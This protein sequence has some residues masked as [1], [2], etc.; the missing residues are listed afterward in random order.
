MERSDQNSRGRI[1]GK[2]DS[3]SDSDWG[4]CRL[5]CWTSTW[6]CRSRFCYHGLSVSLKGWKIRK[7][8]EKTNEILDISSWCFNPYSTERESPY[9]ILFSVFLPKRMKHLKQMPS[10]TLCFPQRLQKL[11]PTQGHFHFEYRK[12]EDMSCFAQCWAGFA[13][14]RFFHFEKISCFESISLCILNCV[15]LQIILSDKGRA[16]LHTGGSFD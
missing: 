9:L 6:G 1:Q 13:F 12:S 16:Q 7:C 2:G 11:T 15:S 3:D 8:L 5:N 14:S 10:W 4:S